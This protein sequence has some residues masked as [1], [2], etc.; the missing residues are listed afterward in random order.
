MSELKLTAT[1]TGGNTKQVTRI[2]NDFLKSRGFD[3]QLL[4]EHIILK[5]SEGNLAALKDQ[6][7]NYVGRTYS[8]KEPIPLT[9]IEVLLESYRT[10][11]LLS[12]PQ[13]V[14]FYA[15]A[16]DRGICNL[17]VFIDDSVVV[18]LQGQIPIS[19]MG[20]INMGPIKLDLPDLRSLVNLVKVEKTD[21]RTNLDR[22]LEVLQSSLLLYRISTKRTGNGSTLAVSTRAKDVAMIKKLAGEI[23]PN[24]VDN[25]QLPIRA[26]GLILGRMSKNGELNLPP[27]IIYTINAAV[28]GLLRRIEIDL[29]DE[30][31]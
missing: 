17:D 8:E 7:N 26:L 1:R 30:R 15:N 16:G 31:K 4:E 9:K 13:S 21:I 19:V 28:R 11:F 3:T 23:D 12:L 14:A 10:K 6:Y 5:N 22:A 18:S 2:L 20:P 24:L 29:F 27:F 25:E